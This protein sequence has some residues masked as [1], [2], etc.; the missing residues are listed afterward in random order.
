MFQI[1]QSSDA[2]SLIQRLI[3]DSECRDGAV[4]AQTTVIVP[5]MAVAQFLDQQIARSRGISARIHYRFWGM[6]EWSLIEQVTGQS[7]HYEQ[8]PLSAVAMHWRIFAY[9]YQEGD[10]ILATPT[11]PLFSPLQTLLQGATQLNAALTQRLWSYAG[12]IARLFVGYIAMRPD[13][14]TRWGKKRSGSK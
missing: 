3:A 1:I 11:H 12:E 8:A 9:L 14:L 5:S 6:F 7:Q 4:F 10:A 2:R 13:W